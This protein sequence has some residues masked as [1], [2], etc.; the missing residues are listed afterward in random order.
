LAVYGILVATSPEVPRREEYETGW[1]VE[2]APAALVPIRRTWEG[3]GG[4]RAMDFADVSAEVAGIVREIPDVVEAGAAVEAGDVI[5]RLD[6]IDFRHEVA[7]AEHAV[8]LLES[9]LQALEVEAGVL[10]D[11]L[12]LAQTNVQLARSAYERAQEACDRGV[13]HELDVEQW[14]REFTAAGQAYEQSRERVQLIPPRRRQLEATLGGERSRL[15]L[16]RRNLERT[17][18]RSPLSG[19]IQR[20]DVEAGERVGPGDSIARIVSL[21][22]IEVPLSF[23]ASARPWLRVGDPVRI[24]G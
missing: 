17:I 18:I 12:G 20:V 9:Q 23:P 13:A 7:A 3:F 6:D 15:E 1:G 10:D 4:A 19:T 24:A 2:V 21:R 8:A 5:A 16:A 11:Q 14:Q 22:R